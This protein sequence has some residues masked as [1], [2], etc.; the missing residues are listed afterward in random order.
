MIG[1]RPARVLENYILLLQTGQRTI[2]S[3][4][5]GCTGE[6]R[7]DNPYAVSWPITMD[8]DKR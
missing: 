2:Y 6:T 7:L 8:H 4:A 5:I 1:T 3:V